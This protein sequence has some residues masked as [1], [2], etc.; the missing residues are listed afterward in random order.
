MIYWWKNMLLLSLLFLRS[1]VFCILPMSTS[2][3]T[4]NEHLVEGV[5]CLWS[6]PTL[7]R[8]TCLNEC[9]C[10]VDRL[11][12]RMP[13]RDIVSTTSS[14]S[15]QKPQPPKTERALETEAGSCQLGRLSQ[16]CDAEL[17]TAYPTESILTERML[18][19]CQALHLAHRHA[20]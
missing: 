15:V 2:L 12:S 18:A 6:W 8:Q 20:L 11:T 17:F 1:V 4:S 3:W 10:A 9:P 5:W 13:C 19:N 14:P 16:M 7:S